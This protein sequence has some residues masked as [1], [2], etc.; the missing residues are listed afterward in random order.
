[1]K[2]RTYEKMTET[3][4]L[5]PIQNTLLSIQGDLRPRQSIVHFISR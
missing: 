1:M 4:Q 5:L 2:N 3:S